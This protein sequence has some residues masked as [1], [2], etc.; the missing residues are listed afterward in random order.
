MK[1]LGTDG[2]TPEE[3]LMDELRLEEEQKK[4]GLMNLELSSGVNGGPAV[5]IVL[6]PKKN[7]QPKQN[8]AKPEKSIKLMQQ[9]GIAG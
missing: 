4:G 3:K 6:D 1:A 2:R 8:L 7:Y 5:N 9:R